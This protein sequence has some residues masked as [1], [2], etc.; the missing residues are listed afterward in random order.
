VVLF[1]SSGTRLGFRLQ[2]ARVW[3]SEGGT[4]NAFSLFQGVARDMNDS[5]QIASDIQWAGY[6]NFVHHGSA[7]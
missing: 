7:E 5:L 1:F 3:P 6:E 4:P 2:A